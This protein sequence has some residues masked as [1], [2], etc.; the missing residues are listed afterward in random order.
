MKARVATGLALAAAAAAL[1][2]WSPVWLFAAL[3]MAV[4]VAALVEWNR[5]GPGGG[6]GPAAVTVAAVVM[7]G[8]GVTVFAA[9]QQL[10]VVCVAGAL[11]W[12]WL[13]WEALR[14]RDAP[15]VTVTVA[16]DARHSK[17]G[18]LAQGAALLWVAWC[19]LVYLRMEHGAGAAV[20]AVAAVAAADS[21]AYFAGKFFGKRKLAASASPSS[22]RARWRGCSRR[23]R[24]GGGW[25]RRR[26]RP[27][28]AWPATCTRAH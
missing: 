27:R 11:L 22:A 20:G 17:F 12:A 4:A 19:A 21:G 15:T 2:W 3:G 24:C 14:H 28:S 9:P 26:W 13:A 5:L 6:A 18:N 23:T 16:A 25:R 1:A 7:A 10:A 8:A